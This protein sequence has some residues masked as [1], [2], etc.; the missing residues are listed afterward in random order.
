MGLDRDDLA[1]RNMVA[2][3]RTLDAEV[4]VPPTLA[5]FAVECADALIARLRPATVAPVADAAP[6]PSAAPP[7][8]PSPA[9]YVPNV[10]DVVHGLYGDDTLGR[11]TYVA[12][13]GTMG[14]ATGFG[15]NQIPDSFVAFTTDIRPATAAER[16][17]AGLDAPASP[18]PAVDREGLAGVMRAAWYDEEAPW[19]EARPRVK[20]DWLRAAD[21]AIAFLKANGGVA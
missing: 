5:D 14:R 12:P 4:R 6:A 19:D 1:A 17:A 10:G 15:R 16:T 7:A 9:A 11:I 18:A 13:N 8:A 20:A 21:A 3:I 2:A